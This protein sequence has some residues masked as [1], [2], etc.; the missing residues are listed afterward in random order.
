MLLFAP[1]Q[2]LDVQEL[3]GVA[4]SIHSV[5]GCGPS[6]SLAANA[7]SSAPAQPDCA[8]AGSAVA[9]ISA[10]RSS[11]ILHGPAGL[12]LRSE[13]LYRTSLQNRQTGSRCDLDGCNRRRQVCLVGCS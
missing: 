8:A 10:S 1:K 12:Q 11:P 7:S 3:L 6:N 13:A 2:G 5:V 9:A 4:S